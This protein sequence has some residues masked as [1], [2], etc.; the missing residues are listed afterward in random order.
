MLLMI[1]AAILFHRAAAY[2]NLGAWK[3][4]G[5]SLLVSIVMNQV[6]PGALPLI[7]AQGVLFGFLWRQ[8]SRK[9]AARP[10][11]WAERAATAQEERAERLRQAREKMQERQA[12]SA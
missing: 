8:N 5:A 1:A 12:R 7:I 4:M 9:V 2:E 6:M 11:E 10:Q 3:W